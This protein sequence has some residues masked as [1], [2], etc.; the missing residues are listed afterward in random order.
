M[1]V[2]TEE[3]SGGSLGGAGSLITRPEIMARALI[4]GG[5][6]EQKAYWLPRIAEGDPPLCDCYHRTG[7]RFRCCLHEAESNPDG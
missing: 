4:E 2:V 5:T 6:E 1:I 3:L 7:F